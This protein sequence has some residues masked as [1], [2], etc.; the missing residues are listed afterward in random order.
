MIEKVF[1]KKDSFDYL[2]KWINDD[3]PTWINSEAFV[4]IQ[5]I[6]D[7]IKSKKLF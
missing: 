3:I 1:L 7:Y 2:V 6:R 4:D 5:I